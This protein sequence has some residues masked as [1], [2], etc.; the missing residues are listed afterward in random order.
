MQKKIKKNNMKVFQVFT[1]YPNP[2]QPYNERLIEGLKKHSILKT[3]VVSFGEKHNKKQKEVI[4]PYTQTFFI[5]IMLMLKE[6]ILIIKK[7]GIKRS[8]IKKIKTHVRYSFILKNKNDIFHF[9]NLYSINKE[10]LN[11]L[12]ENKIKYIVSLRGYDVTIKPLLNDKF[13]K[14]LSEIL[15]N[16]WKIHS[17][18]ESLKQEAINLT[19]IEEAKICVIY[20][21]PNLKNLTIVK[22]I[23]K[24]DSSIN[25]FTISR[26]HWKKCIS[27]SLISLKLLLDKGYKVNY[28]LIGGF[29]G[30]EDEKIIYLIKKLNLTKNVIIHG[31]LNESEYTKLLSEMHICWIPTINEGLPNTLYYVLKS[32]FPTIAA[33][34]DGIPE[35]LINEKNGLLFEPYNFEDLAQKTIK[36]IDDNLFRKQIYKNLKN[37]V[38]QN[39]ENEIKE[40]VK[41]YTLI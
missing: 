32:G 9:H 19:N 23:D 24:F 11:I 36:I 2:Y 37:T 4:Y 8:I 27:E 1:S 20:R 17:V 39:E 15:H 16:S 12:V 38:L 21:T 26:I 35:I 6:M 10:L 40:Y 29:Q 33:N 22:E 7:E 41:L 28:H 18:C 3:V 13:A 34:T 5:K 14:Q 30:Y 25:I 31:F